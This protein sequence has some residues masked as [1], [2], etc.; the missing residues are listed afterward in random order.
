MLTI[1]D[2]L[3]EPAGTSQGT[4]ST[5]AP[6]TITLK[7]LLTINLPHFSGGYEKWREFRDLFTSK[8]ATNSSFTNGDRMYY[9]KTNVEGEAANSRL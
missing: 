1:V 7:T 4:V 2:S 9:L 3:L 6:Q 8:I 5:Q